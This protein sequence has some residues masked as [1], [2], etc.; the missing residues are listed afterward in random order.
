MPESSLKNY[1]QSLKA[2][3][4]KIGKRLKRIFP[5]HNAFSAEPD[6]LQ[7]HLLASTGI[8]E[9]ETVKAGQGFFGP[10]VERKWYDFSLRTKNW[11]IE[12]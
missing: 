6:L 10:Y 11:G 7:R 3:S 4:E 1:R 2:L 9:P 12:A 8:I 5:G